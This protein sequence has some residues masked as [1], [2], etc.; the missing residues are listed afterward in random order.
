MMIMIGAA[1]LVLVLGVGGL[2][3]WRS[4]ATAPAPLSVGQ[5]AAT[6]PTNGSTPE[7]ETPA[8]EGEPAVVSRGCAE[9]ESAEACGD[10]ERYTEAVAAKDAARCADISDAQARDLCVGAA[11]AAAADPSQ[12]DRIGEDGI[13]TR[14]TERAVSAQARAQGNPAVCASLGSDAAAA[15]EGE[16]YAGYAS[17]DR[18]AELS[19]EQ[20]ANC[21]VYFAEIA[22]PAETQTIT[23]PPADGD[24]DGDGLTNGQE[25]E[26]GSDP[27]NRD[28]D[29]DT[30]PDGEEVQNG[31]NPLGPGRLETT[32]P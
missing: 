12:C 9:R 20:A 19:G 13:R 10:A 23:M 14:C 22:P 32:T 21:N 4:R 5:S 31:Y 30:F 1:V 11:A 28:T 24:E 18:C 26:Y 3:V 6:A 16:V 27:F 8:P 7:S 2:L 17:A 25:I 29:G 15:C